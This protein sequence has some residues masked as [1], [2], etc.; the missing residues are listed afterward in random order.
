MRTLRDSLRKTLA[1]KHRGKNMI[2]AVAFNEVKDYFSEK[3][4]MISDQFGEDK[5]NLE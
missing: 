4:K 1:R 5:L 2:G 3:L